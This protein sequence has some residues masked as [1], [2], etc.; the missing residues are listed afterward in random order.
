MKEA[1]I[2][3]KKRKAEDDARWEG[4]VTSYWSPVLLMHYHQR[5]ER[6]AW[7]VGGLSVANR[8]KRRKRLA[9]SDK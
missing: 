6:L 3:M 9:C 8:R 1:E 4:M 5:I 7:G 2:S